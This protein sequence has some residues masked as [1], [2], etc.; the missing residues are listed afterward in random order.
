MC[1]RDRS[2]AVAH[3]VQQVVNGIF[4]MNHFSIARVEASAFLGRADGVDGI[5]Q[6][7]KCLR[8]EI[9]FA[10]YVGFKCQLIQRCEIPSHSGGS[11]DG[12]VEQ[13]YYL[14]AY[15]HVQARE[16]IC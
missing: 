9:G 14:C 15:D 7:G 6:F 13:N 8:V 4:Q 10:Q 16:E 11:G 3:S 1:I 2:V 12:S 5:F